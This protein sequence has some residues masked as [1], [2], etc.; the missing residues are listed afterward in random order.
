MFA[1]PHPVLLRQTQSIYQ[2]PATKIPEEPSWQVL[3]VADL[4]AVAIQGVAEMPVGH[5]VF[6]ATSAD[7]RAADVQED[8]AN[9]A[10]RLLSP[11]EGDSRSTQPPNSS[12]NPS[13]ENEGVPEESGFS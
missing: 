3:A 12:K 1:H 8:D 13:R 11:R 7:L 6:V 2:K 9:V 5:G 10:K 4:P